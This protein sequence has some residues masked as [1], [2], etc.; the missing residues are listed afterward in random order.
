MVSNLFELDDSELQGL[1]D[2]ETISGVLQ[3]FGNELQESLR[4]SL[5]TAVHGITAQALKQ[6]VLFQ[7]SIP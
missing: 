2:D 6:S 1:G 3:N 4:R 7:Y 5:D